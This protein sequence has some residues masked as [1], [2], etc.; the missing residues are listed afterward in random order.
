MYYRYF[1]EG[2]LHGIVD[3]HDFHFAVVIYGNHSLYVWDVHDE[4]KVIFLHS[5]PS[6]DLLFVHIDLST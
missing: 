6:T 4:F 5:L 2:S 1:K 3:L